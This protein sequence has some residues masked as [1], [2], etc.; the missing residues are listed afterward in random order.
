[1][2]YHI[3]APAATPDNP[4]PHFHHRPLG[5]VAA[6]VARSSGKESVRHWMVQAA[7]VEDDDERRA[8][9]EIAGKIASLMGLDAD[10]IGPRATP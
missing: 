3:T 1:M 7:Q 8:A 9:L 10:L 6:T 2:R 5:P 4:K